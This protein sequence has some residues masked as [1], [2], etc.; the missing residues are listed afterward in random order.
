MSTDDRQPMGNGSSSTIGN[1]GAEPVTQCCIELLE[2]REGFRVECTGPEAALAHFPVSCAWCSV[3]Y[4]RSMV[5]DSHGLCQ[6]CFDSMG[7]L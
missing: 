3:V 7:D 4:G 5:K 6:E 2:D 1:D